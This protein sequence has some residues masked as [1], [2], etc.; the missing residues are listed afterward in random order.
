MMDVTRPPKE[1]RIALLKRI[2]EIPDYT[3]DYSSVLRDHLDDPEPEVRMLALEGLWGYPDPEL[4]PPLLAAAENDP[5]EQVRC[6]AI[7]TLGRYIYEGEM[8]DFDVDYGP[9][10]E[11]LRLDTLPQEDF[12]KVKA[13]LLGVYRDESKTL[14][15]RRFAVEALSF[16]NDEEIFAITEEAYSHP[17]P[18]MKLS[19]I[20]GMG[21][22]GN[23]RWTEIIL[24]EL[25]NPNPELQREA[26]RAAGEAGLTDAG[27]DLW[28]LTYAED[29]ETQLEA[30]W[31]LGQSGWEGAFDRLDELSLFS[32]DSEVQET[33]EAALEEWYIYSG[34]M[35]GELLDENAFDLDDDLETFVEGEEEW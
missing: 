3:T 9:A 11:T 27:K 22:S 18:K 29:R 7:I 6:R 16:L 25:H 31:A 33:A 24:K 15:E 10:D 1:E 21:R 12:L 20:F 5:N 2:V 19:A 17:E 4:I 13:F 26:I 14:D 32:A 30:I 28:R 34:A 23:M 35:T 8:G